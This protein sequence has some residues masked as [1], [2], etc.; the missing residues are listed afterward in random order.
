M[1][2]QIVTFLGTIIL[3]FILFWLLVRKHLGKVIFSSFVCFL[4]LLSASI[5][6]P[7]SILKIAEAL[8]MGKKV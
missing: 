6:I 5:V 8:N 4:V 7:T 1:R 3:Y 2:N